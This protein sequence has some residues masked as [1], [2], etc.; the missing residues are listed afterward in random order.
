MTISNLIEAVQKA[1]MV[2]FSEVIATIDTHFI[3][4]PTPFTNGTVTNEANSNN[5]SCKVF[6]FAKMYQLNEKDTLFLF[7]EHYQKVLAT[8]KEMDHQNIRNFI[9]SGWEGISFEGNALEL[10]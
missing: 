6:S 2:A 5:G 1:E 3:F 8:P 4:T 10:K 7:G 9:N